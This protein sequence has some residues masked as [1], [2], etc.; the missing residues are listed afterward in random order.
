MSDYKYFGGAVMGPAG[1]RQNVEMTP[2]GTDYRRTELHL[3]L[4][5]I[6]YIPFIPFVPASW[7]RA[8]FI[9]DG[10]F[11]D[12]AGGEINMGSRRS[13][14]FVRPGFRFRFT[15]PGF[16]VADVR[17]GAGV[18]SNN[19]NFGKG[20]NPPR[21]YSINVQGQATL[22]AIFCLNPDFCLGAVVG[23]STDAAV[24]STGRNYTST[25]FPFLGLRFE[26]QVNAPTRPDEEE[27]PCKKEKGECAERVK[28]VTREREEWR[29]RYE[30]K[31]EELKVA[32]A[33]RPPPSKPGPEQGPVA[34]AQ[35][36]REIGYRWLRELPK[37]IHFQNDK[38]DLLPLPQQFP[39]CKNKC[40]DG[41]PILNMVIFGVRRWAKSV[42][43][44]SQGGLPAY[45][46]EIFL[47]GF[48]NDTGDQG[49]NF[50][51]ANNRRANVI[52]YLSGDSGRRY[53]RRDYEGQVVLP[54]DV[55]TKKK[56]RGEDRLQF[57]DFVAIRST[58]TQQDPAE[59]IIMALTGKKS[60]DLT[61]AER[62]RIQ[63]Q[64]KGEEWRKV[65]MTYKVYKWGDGKYRE[66]TLDQYIQEQ[67][68]GMSQKGGK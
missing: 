16:I 45:K 24:L 22:G 30:E 35:D 40:G 68:F 31:V 33:D 41:N 18:A 12:T 21:E 3:G 14:V 51:L 61:T 43:Q 54:L 42:M 44:L 25:H 64:V 56:G 63:H 59:D 60:R 10:S 65:E 6:N 38:A 62:E 28:I 67:I 53:A 49:H 55:K 1:V 8:T 58:E 47:H 32:I 66:I 2:Y 23:A 34:T 50:A 11:E 27:R 13:A 17:F 15:A 36:P 37:G 26:G 5:N 46:M 57:G 48:A 4:E 20:I 52:D 9:V 39:Q 7:A 29:T 19:L